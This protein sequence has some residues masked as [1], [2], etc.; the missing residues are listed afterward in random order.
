MYLCALQALVAFDSII[1]D[2]PYILKGAKK[3][4]YECGQQCQQCQAL[5]Q[6][7]CQWCPNQFC[8]EHD[9]GCS[10]KQ[11]STST[12]WYDLPSLT[13]SVAVRLVQ[14]RR[15]KRC[16]VRLLNEYRAGIYPCGSLI[17]I[18]EC[19]NLTIAIEA[20]AKGLSISARKIGEIRWQVN[21]SLTVH[22]FVVT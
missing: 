16:I 7:S 18:C 8:V 1:A 9:T 6:R 3:H 15:S 2:L 10:S 13:C 20:M 17:C 5:T 22:L 14:C 21:K 19:W 4:C 11:V 12:F